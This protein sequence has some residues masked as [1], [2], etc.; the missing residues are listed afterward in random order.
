MSPG[1]AERMWSVNLDAAIS[2]EYQTLGGHSCWPS[3]E[4]GGPATSLGVPTTSLGAGGNSSDKAGS[5]GDRSGSTS[6]HS[7]AVRENNI[8]FGNAAG[9]PGNHSYYLSFNDF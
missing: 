5:A 1:M 2:G 7:R 4:L 9:V 6:N 8:L 3:E